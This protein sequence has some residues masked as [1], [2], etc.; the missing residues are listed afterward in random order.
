MRALSEADEG[1]RDRLKSKLAIFHKTWD[2]VR[3]ENVSSNLKM[4]E[5]KIHLP[6]AYE[7]LKVALDNIKQKMD[8]ITFDVH[9]FEFRYQEEIVIRLIFA[10]IINVLIKEEY[11]CKC[12]SNALKLNV[13]NILLTLGYLKHKYPGTQKIEIFIN[14][15]TEN[16]GMVWSL[17]DPKLFKKQKKEYFSKMANMLPV[18]D[19][20]WDFFYK[21]TDALKFTISAEADNKLRLLFGRIVEEDDRKKRDEI[22]QIAVDLVHGKPV[23]LDEEGNLINPNNIE[24]ASDNDDSSDD[25]Y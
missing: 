24:L 9:N 2:K 21:T 3:A 15:V 18:I 19:H 22:T 17:W 4:E 7:V 13:F 12:P 25:D 5:V 10:C 1:L 16:L 23:Q 20:L 8:E 11:E 6:P 14:G